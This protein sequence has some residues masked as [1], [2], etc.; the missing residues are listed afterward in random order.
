MSN[1]VMDNS[2][3]MRLS[4]SRAGNIRKGDLSKV[5]TDADKSRLKLGKVLFVGPEY[6][7]ISAFDNALSSWV[8]LRAINVD[9]GFKG[10]CIMPKG[11]ISEVDKRLESAT[12]ERAG[13]VEAFLSVLDDEREKARDRMNGQFKAADYPDRS[14]LLE[15][16]GVKWSYLSLGVAENLPPEMA[17]RERAKLEA[18]FDQVGDDVQNALRVGL[19]DLVG[20]LAEKLKPS[21]DGKKKIFRDSAVGNLS[22]FLE[23]FS[24]RNITDD[25]ELAA[26]A[27]SAEN[28][29]QGVSPEGLRGR[30]GLAA[31][32]AD[33]LEG[34]KAAVS[35]L[36]EVQPGRKF[37]LE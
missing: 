27:A 10:V 35:D 22:E 3:L 11:L 37:N 30:P 4:F 29:L 13:L 8:N 25:S 7:A 26:L 15:R 24:A 5:A 23:L 20:H 19:R 33:G 34:V 18:R 14:D 21:E 12:D 6:A 31:S 9:T 17:E 16:F 36:I 28:L 32:V 2:V 1:N